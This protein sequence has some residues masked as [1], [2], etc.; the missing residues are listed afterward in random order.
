MVPAAAPPVIDVEASGFGRGSYPI[1][2]GVAMPDGRTHCY[3]LRPEDDW[4]HW[5]PAAE[6]VHRIGREILLARG[7]PVADVADQLNELLSGMTVYS[8][9]WGHDRSW[10]ATLYDA[11]ERRQRFT[12]EPLRRLLPETALG[13]WHATRVQVQ[14]ALGATRHRASADALVIQRTYVAC[15]QSHR[16]G[17][18]QRIVERGVERRA[19]NP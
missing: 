13:D 18:G 12:L 10:I 4:Q 5:D 3:L 7:R 14:E 11:A 8:D 15:L 6:T 2:I 16:Q 9:A 17:P 1:E 19:D